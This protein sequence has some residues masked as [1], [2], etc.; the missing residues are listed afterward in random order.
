MSSQAFLFFIFPLNPH[1]FLEE[2]YLIFLLGKGEIGENGK[3]KIG[4]KDI[5]NKQIIGINLKQV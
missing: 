5:I 3:K 4:R 1:Q 2:K